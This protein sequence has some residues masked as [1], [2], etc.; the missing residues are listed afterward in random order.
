MDKY[1]IYGNKLSYF[2]RKLQAGLEFSGLNYDFKTKNNGNKEEIERRSNT[3]QI[4]ILLTPEGW[5][6][7]DTT[8]LLHLIDQRIN[9]D[10]FFPKSVTGALCY[11]IEQYFD[12]WLP[13]AAI[14]YR[15]NF[16]NSSKIAK[17]QL[18]VGMVDA[19]NAHNSDLIEQLGNGIE[20]WGKNKATRAL[21]LLNEPE[22]KQCED[23]L[24]SVFK[25]FD[26]HFTINK[27]LLKNKPCCV[28][29]VLLGSLAAHFFCDSESIQQLIPI[30]PTLYQWYEDNIGPNKKFNDFTKLDHDELDLNNDLPVCFDKILKEMGKLYIQFV[31]QNQEALKNKKKAFTLN[32]YDNEVSMLTREYPEKSRLLL[33]SW[34][35]RNLDS[36]QINQL[37]SLLSGYNLLDLI[38]IPSP[39]CKL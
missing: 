5:M 16:E 27:F 4:P 34:I 30:N 24:K 37:K 10:L 39:I 14:H 8:P 31:L 23:E 15:W 33:V 32:I 19:E 38:N 12:E 17:K 11:L 21:G 35:H 20:F 6:I 22:Q 7:N 29:A 2:T 13:R 25:A 36:D 3:H 18:A 26:E 28:D 1:I 9:H